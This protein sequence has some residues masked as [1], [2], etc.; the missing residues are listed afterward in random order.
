MITRTELDNNKYRN[1]ITYEVKVTDKYGR[2]HKLTNFIGT[3]FYKNFPESRK[4]SEP[5]DVIKW[6]GRYDLYL[7]STDNF[8]EDMHIRYDNLEDALKT[9][10]DLNDKYIGDIHQHRELSDGTI[11]FCCID[12]NS[13]LAKEVE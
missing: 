6:L 10:Y 9:M 8:H 2:T 11:D 4:L 7:H 13:R 12:Y 1:G 3:I 5:Y